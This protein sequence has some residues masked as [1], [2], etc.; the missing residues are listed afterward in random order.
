MTG[1]GA[2]LGKGPRVPKGEK[3]YSGM[4]KKQKM[5]THIRKGGKKK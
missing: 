4:P 5:K 2:L 1:F 3:S